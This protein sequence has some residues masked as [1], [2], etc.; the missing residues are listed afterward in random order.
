MTTQSDTLVQD[1]FASMERTVRR[2]VLWNRFWV[3]LFVLGAVGGAGW[4][5][6]RAIDNEIKSLDVTVN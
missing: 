1:R 4:W 3:L 6:L 2:L 5:R